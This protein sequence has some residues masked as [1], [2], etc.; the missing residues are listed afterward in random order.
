LTWNGYANTTGMTAMDYRITDNCAD[1]PGLTEHLHTEKLLR[2]PNIYMAFEPPAAGPEINALPALHT[3]RI[4]F[5]SFNAITKISSVVV[6]TWSRILASLPNADLLVATLPSE[7]ARNRLLAAF[8]DHGIG[9]ERIRLYGKLPRNEFLALHGLADIALDPFPFHGTT[10][11][12]HSLWMGLPVVAL[13]GSSHASRVGVSMLTS[14]GL[15]ELIARTED[16][17]CE[18]AL[19]LAR[20]LEKLSRLRSSMRERML[21]SPLT[22]SARF[23]R[24]L[25]SAYRTI[26]RAWCEQQPPGN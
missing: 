22:D 8:A 21:S 16:E 15:P 11:T 14:V 9:A 5:G 20:D 6:R 7:L 25:E 3:G 24:H 17:Y 23:A 4:T 10:T 18:I 13:A 1:P 2:M 19:D 26:W 12:C